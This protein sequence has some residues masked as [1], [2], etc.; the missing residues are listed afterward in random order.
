M[1]PSLKT[2]TSNAVLQRRGQAWRYWGHWC[3]RA[4]VAA[5]CL[6]LS[7]ATTATWAASGGLSIERDISWGAQAGQTLDLYRPDASTPPAL[8]AS[9]A[10]RPGR[11][12]LLLVHGGG[13][14]HG[15][16]GND[17]VVENK[18]AH[19]TAQ[20]AVLVSINYRL[21]PQADP[22]QQAR[23]VAQ[24]LAFVQGRAE[25]WGVDAERVVLVGHSAGAHLVSLLSADTALALAQ[26]AKPW[27]ATLALDS[28]AM[29]VPEIMQSRH[30][31]LYDRAFGKDGAYWRE[32]SPWHRLGPA[33]LP[34]LLVCSSRRATSCSQ[35]RSFADKAVSLGRQAEV[36]E[37]DLSH[38]EINEQL[39]L[40][41]GYTE[42]VDAF[43]RRQAGF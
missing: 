41:G 1:I 27:R 39:G 30:F 40:A 4:S 26:G 16:K 20:G 17:R 37:Q 28:A 23:E 6:A 18:V 38:G 36:S 33:P 43:L 8:T 13:W 15:D 12:L 21:L 5:W 22:M 24:A 34:M 11:P 35:A 2:P 32:A 9:Q 3:Q 10:R 14:A 7:L 19:W 31:G 42:R 29:N 25:A